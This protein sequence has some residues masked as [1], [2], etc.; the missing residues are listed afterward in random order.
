VFIISISLVQ[1]DKHGCSPLS[2]APAQLRFRHDSYYTFTAGLYY[3]SGTTD[4]VPR[5]YDGM[6]GRK[7][8][9]KK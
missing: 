4:T 9:I 3:P 2:A 6:E 1:P 8:Q 5:A 7:I